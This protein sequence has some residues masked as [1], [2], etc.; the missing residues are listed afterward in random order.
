MEELLRLSKC[1][2]YSILN[3]EHTLLYFLRVCV[4][5]AERCV[6]E[7]EQPETGLHLGCYRPQNL[8]G[9]PPPPRSKARREARYGAGAEEGESPQESAF[10]KAGSAK[11][12]LGKLF[13]YDKTCPILVLCTV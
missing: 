8:G 9:S 2:V 10:S 3:N 1:T 12:G 13:S 7:E 5:L 11:E 6:R 4:S